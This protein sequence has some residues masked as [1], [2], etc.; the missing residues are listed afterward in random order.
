LLDASHEPLTTE[1]LSR[2][3][4]LIREAKSKSR[5]GRHH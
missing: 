3:E 4:Q 1:A 2:L 5:S